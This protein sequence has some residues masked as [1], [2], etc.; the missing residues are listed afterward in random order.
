[1]SC[2]CQSHVYHRVLTTADTQKGVWTALY[3]SSACYSCPQCFM[4]ILIEF[5]IESESPLVWQE[6]STVKCLPDTIQNCGVEMKQHKHNPSSRQAFWV[7]QRELKKKKK[8]RLCCCLAALPFP[9]LISAESHT[10]TRME[11]PVMLCATPLGSDNNN[12]LF[13]Y[14]P[15]LQSAHCHLMSQEEKDRNALFPLLTP[16]LPHRLPMSLNNPQVVTVVQFSYTSFS[17]CWR[18]SSSPPRLKQIINPSALIVWVLRDWSQQ[19]ARTV[20]QGFAVGS[21][22]CSS[23][24][25][26]IR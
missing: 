4:V 17:R 25:G 23:E 15:F 24:P 9:F 21:W 18:S 6:D 19:E 26:L 5:P 7:L 12:Y 22:A 8:K 16:Q 13:H 20:L 1:M 3:V 10:S 11:K 14:P 2:F